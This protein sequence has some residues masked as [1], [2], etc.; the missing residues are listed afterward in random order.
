MRNEVYR[1]KNKK[2][3]R[4]KRDERRRPWDSTES[5]PR[6]PAEALRPRGRQATCAAVATLTSARISFIGLDLFISWERVD[7]R[8][9]GFDVRGPIRSRSSNLATQHHHHPTSR[10]R[11]SFFF[12]LFVAD[13]WAGEPRWRWRTWNAP[14]WAWAWNASVWPI[15]WNCCRWPAPA[16]SP[17]PPSTGSNC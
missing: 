16:T 12:W 14:G 3:E 17:T 1:I 8:T 13:S 2:M 7:G 15:C 6:D 9:R 11:V 10:H 4:K 5:I